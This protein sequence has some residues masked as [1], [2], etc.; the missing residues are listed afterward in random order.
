LFRIVKSNEDFF[1]SGL[2]ARI[3]FAMPPDKPSQWT[4]L[5]TSEEAVADYENIF[6]TLWQ[7]RR[8]TEKPNPGT[9]LLVKLSPDA[10]EQFVRFYNAN[11]LERCELTGDMK[12]SWAKFT[13]YAARLALVFHLVQ[14]IEDGE[15]MDVLQG[16]AMQRA[17]RL[18]DWFKR[19]TMRIIRFL[20]QPVNE[21]KSEA[22]DVLALISEN[23]GKI[24]AAEL[25]HRRNKYRG[26][27]GRK[28]AVTLLQGLVQE[29][30]LK[31]IPEKSNNG[32]ELITYTLA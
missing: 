13:G 6:R 29:G 5:E 2:T 12:A 22:D 21:I 23:G 16:D 10:K 24:T 32:R 31:A 28:Q 20:R 26:K 15:S 30:R 14:S 27:E 19:E 18:I 4:E 9:P 11:S 17:I 3:L 1:D 25:H 7:W 8:D